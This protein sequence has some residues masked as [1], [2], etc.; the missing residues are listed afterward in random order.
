MVGCMQIAA[1]SS[2]EDELYASP[3][4]GAREGQNGA[5]AGPEADA[6]EAQV[7]LLCA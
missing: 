3:G 5:D 7:S 2:D 1:Q 4:P 6:V